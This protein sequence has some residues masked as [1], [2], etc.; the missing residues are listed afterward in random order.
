MLYYFGYT[1]APSIPGVAEEKENATAF[2]NF[3]EHDPSIS[4]LYY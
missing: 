1:N 3:E 4:H 2:F